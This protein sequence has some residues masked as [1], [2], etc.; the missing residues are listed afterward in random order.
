VETRS[1]FTYYFGGLV[2][3]RRSTLRLPRATAFEVPKSVELE[4]RIGR[5]ELL[6]KDLHDEN[7]ALK[8]RVSALQAQ[9]DHVAARKYERI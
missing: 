5:L 7:A 6:I 4:H 9:L 3:R 1:V 8:K 2:T